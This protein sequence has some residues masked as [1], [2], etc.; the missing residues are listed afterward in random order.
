MNGLERGDLPPEIVTPPPGPR[1]R[2]LAARL[3]RAEAPGIN[4]LGPGDLPTVVWREALGANVLDVDGNRFVDLTSG[5]GVAAVGHRHPRVVAAVG[6]QA[7]RLLHGLADA[8]AHPARLELAERLAALAPVDDARVH[9]AVSGADAVEIALKT[10][11]AATGRARVLAFEPAYHG[12]SL[13]ALA[14]SSRPEFRA[15]FAAHL[16]AHVTRLAFG[17]DPAAVDRA[18]AAAPFAAVLVEPVVGR[19]GVLVPPAGWLAAVAAA[20]RRHGALLVAD[21]IFTGFGRTGRWFAVER[22]GVRPDLLCCG[23]ALGGGL[24]IGAVLGTRRAMEVW[25]AGGEA[26]HT[27]TFV[28]HPLAC[29]AALATLDVLAD[30][31]LV[32]RAAALGLRLGEA[33]ARAAAGACAVRG[34]GAL[35]GLE[36]ASAAAARQ[37]AAAARAA[38]VLVLAGGAAGRVVQVAPPLVIAELQLERALAVLAAACA[39]PAQRPG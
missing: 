39:A 12:V 13:G 38:G 22:D 37:A 28:A 9:F 14:A 20:A 18:L 19:E 30:E 3:A 11:V 34:V 36:F 35:W 25:R 17:A 2:A 1:S 23:K 26:L 24:P 8:A 29:A 10:A 16:H 27:G 5:F 31:Q 4:T 32:T 6:A 21:E 33:L 15:P 7:A